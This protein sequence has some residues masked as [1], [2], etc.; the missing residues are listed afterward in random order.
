MKGLNHINYLQA[1]DV[2]DPGNKI[3]QLFLL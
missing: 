2:P 3:I 1:I